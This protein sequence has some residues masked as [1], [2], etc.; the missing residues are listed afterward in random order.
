[1]DEDGFFRRHSKHHGLELTASQPHQ[2]CPQTPRASLTEWPNTEERQPEQ[3]S[4]RGIEADDMRLGEELTR[5][6]CRRRL[7]ELDPIDLTKALAITVPTQRH[8]TKS[9]QGP[10]RAILMDLLSMI[11]TAQQ[12]GDWTT[13]ERAEKLL[14]LL[15]RCVL[16]APP[17]PQHQEQPSRRARNREAYTMQRFQKFL[18]GE[19]SELLEAE[20]REG[21]RSLPQLESPA[22]GASPVPLPMEI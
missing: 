15:P 5:A 3:A 6:A 8:T 13:R 11:N 2:F 21:R 19:W 7:E 16:R 12:T 1:M 14:L 4:S 17:P 22:G 9:F 18:Q 10:F 20:E